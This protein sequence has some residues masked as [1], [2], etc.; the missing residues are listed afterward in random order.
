MNYVL[1]FPD[2]LRAESLGCYGHPVTQ[3]PNYDRVVREGTLFERNYTPHPVCAASRQ[4]LVTGWYPHVQG[5]RTLRYEIDVSKPNFFKYL[6]EAG[7]KTCLSAKNHCFDQ[8]ATQASFDRV[9]SFA[10]SRDMWKDVA[11][12]QADVQADKKYD[13]SMV[14][15]PVP[16][17]KVED[18]PD[19]KFVEAGLQFIR[20]MSAEKSP[21]FMFFS[22]NYPHCP[23]TAPEEFYNMYDPDTLPP[24][25]DLSWLEGKPKLYDLIR[26]YRQSGQPDEWIYKKMN[27]IYLGMISYT[28]ML[29]GRII[30]TLEKEGLFD[31]TTIIICSDHGDFAGD[32]GMPEK[33]PSAM[34]DMLTR[35]PLI[36][37][38]PGC[39]GG[40]RVSELTQSFD[41]FPTVLDFEG[42]QIR[43]DQFGVSLRRQVEGAA[44]DPAR[45]VYCEGGYDT[46]EPHCFEGTNVF[47]Y[48]ILNFPGGDYYP[49]MQQQQKK[50]E[51]VCRVVM[52][53]D[54]RY[55]L[56][57]RTNGENEFYDMQE[58][59]LEY[60]NLY[61]S[62]EHQTL[63]NEKTKQMLTW[64]IHTS[65]V[66]PWEGHI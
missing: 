65:D 46:R 14:H 36:I 33:W 27:A 66:V 31:D 9:V 8:E 35:V 32:V 13:Y 47:P 39:T 21:F 29:L 54:E 45:V 16:A 34:D 38:R 50:P 23:Y 53:R 17:D 48:T 58:D 15:P 22:T 11:K 49:K 10:H 59:P 26:Q 63:I 28:D 43:H 60:K 20:D 55:K 3:T 4:A 30:D 12:D 24:L 2:E 19:H 64:L 5:Y 41:I 56:N 6:R 44:G 42:I 61:N 37:R 25:R 18:I 40:H 52:Q 1:F 62:P 7:F 57:V 51:S